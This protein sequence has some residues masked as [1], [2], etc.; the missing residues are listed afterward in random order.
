MVQYRHVSDKITRVELHLAVLDL[1]VVEFNVDF[2]RHKDDEAGGG[3]LAERHDHLAGAEG[4]V[5]VVD[6][7][8]VEELLLQRV[9]RLVV[10]VHG[11]DEGE[12]GDSKHLVL[13]QM[14]DQTH[15]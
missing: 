12:Y 10:L 6:Q 5:L 15:L 4:A 3:M 11:F 1:W 2:A 7:H 9:V 13:V 14:A 8:I